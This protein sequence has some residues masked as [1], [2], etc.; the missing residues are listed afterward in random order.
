MKKAIVCIVI[1]LIVYLV[2]FLII[3]LKNEKKEIKKFVIFETLPQPQQQE[4]QTPQKTLNY[5]EEGLHALREEY[6]GQRAF[7]YF[8]KSIEEERN[9]MAVMMIAELYS[10]GVH[11]SVSPN[12]IVAARVY[13]TVIENSEKFPESLVRISQQKYNDLLV[14][15]NERDTDYDFNNDVLP[16][17]FPWD[18]ARLLVNFASINTTQHERSNMFT[19]PLIPHMVQHAEVVAPMILHE[20]EQNNFDED[21]EEIAFEELVINNDTQNVHSTSVITCTLVVLEEIESKVQRPMSFEEARDLV[22]DK[23]LKLPNVSFDHVNQVIRALNDDSHVRYKRSDKY[24][25]RVVVTRIVMYPEETRENLLEI[26]SM[27]LDSA[28][29]RN[30]IVCNTGRIVRMLSVFD[31]VDPNQQRVIPEWVLDEELAN[32]AIKTRE[33]SLKS[34]SPEELEEYESLTNDS[35]KLRDSMIS[36]FEKEVYSEYSKIFSEDVLK[37]KIE[38]YSVGF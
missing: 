19:H 14:Y 9:P 4:Q 11:G 18:L 27:Q 1:L 21:I 33:S 17:D 8:T 31:G 36:K 25:F 35:S 13:R 32:L 20:R 22:L 23:T 37:K 38:V 12:K 7:M 5:F 16:V 2:Y 26:L 30:Q 34:A 24:I 10:Q 6:D 3:K 28:V 29:E 15:T